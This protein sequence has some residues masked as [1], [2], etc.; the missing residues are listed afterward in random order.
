MGYG[1]V[2][3]KYV[4]LAGSC[5]VSAPQDVRIC[6]NGGIASGRAVIEDHGAAGV[7]ATASGRRLGCADHVPARRRLHAVPTDV[8]RRPHHRDRDRFAMPCGSYPDWKKVDSPSATGP[9][10][11][12]PSN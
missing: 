1:G 7:D 8:R 10:R 12:A 11:L 9:M 5:G 6:P 4:Q 3:R 2:T